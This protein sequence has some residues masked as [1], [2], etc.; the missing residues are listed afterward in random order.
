MHGNNTGSADAGAVVAP[1]FPMHDGEMGR[2]IRDYDWSRTKLGPIGSWP[3][4]LKTAVELA[5]GTPVPVVLLFGEDGILIYNDGYRVFAGMRHPQILGMPV[6]QAWPEVADYNQL[7]MDTC[8][9]GGTL[10][11]REKLMVLNRH[12]L[13]EDVWLDLDYSPIRDD[14]GK[15]FGVFVTVIETTKKLLAER[16][17]RAR[18]ADLARA[19]QIGGVGGV[20]VDLVNNFKNKRS[21]EYLRIHGLPPEAVNETHGDWVRRIHPADREKTEKQFLDAV[22]GDI[23]DY[24]AHHSSKIRSLNSPL[25]P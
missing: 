21:P 20:E 10:S 19:Q 18:E 24:R 9:A 16:E 3:Q 11:P 13:M 4:S 15:P 17:L 25:Y 23:R 22:K 2:L 8:L 12:G 5:L 6:L 1:R 7:V 14:S